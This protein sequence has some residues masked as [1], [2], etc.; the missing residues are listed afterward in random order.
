MGDTK[1]TFKRYE[2]KYLL[3]PEKFR[4]I[5]E[6]IGGYIEPDE[7]PQSTVCSVYYDGGDYH[8]IR[9]SIDKPVYKE[10]LRLRSYGVPAEGDTVFLE[11]KK[12]FKGV[13]YKRRAPMPVAEAEAYL[14]GEAPAPDS[15]QI[16]NEI[17]WFLKENT[18]CP[19]V[20]IACDRLSLRGREDRELRIT[21]DENIRWRRSELSLTAGSHGEL[22]MKDGGVLMEIKIPGAAPLWLART[23]SELEIFPVS[24]S[25]YGICYTENILREQVEGLVFDV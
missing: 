20:L 21:F 5:K 22:L 7:F 25:K 6:R 16:I 19:K 3:T 1:L 23:L 10:K 15:G 18:L 8:L 14:A 17:D 24:F 4:L 11:L 9:H 2:K 13:V 12:K